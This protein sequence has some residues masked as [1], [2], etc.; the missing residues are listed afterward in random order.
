MK[1]LSEVIFINN[2]PSIDLHGYDSK[3][4]SIYIKEFINDNYKLK[5]KVFTIVHGIGTGILK[6]ETH[7]ILKNDKR[8]IE[9]KTFFHNQGCTLALIN[10]DKIK[11]I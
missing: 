3:T 1:S 10:I 4:A 7:K 2:L 8:V 9:Y 11:K 5:N 6:K